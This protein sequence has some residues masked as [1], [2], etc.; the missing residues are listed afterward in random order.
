MGIYKPEKCAWRGRSMTTKK[1]WGEETSWSALPSIVGKVLSI[2]EGHRTS[3]KYN[4]NKDEVFYVKSGTVEFS[5]ADE[6]W[7]HYRD[8]PVKTDV[9]KQ[10]DSMMVQS[11][12][13]YR[14]KGIT[15]CEVIEIGNRPGGEPV[16][17]HDDYG[18]EVS[19]AVFPNPVP[20]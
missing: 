5:H 17:L 14:I 11:H 15:D 16:R 13:V 10:G 8:H 6:E 2:R 18:R 1:P 4:P 9:L 3:L 19:Q 7:L 20:E 12:C